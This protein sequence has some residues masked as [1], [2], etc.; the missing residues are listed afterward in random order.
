MLEDEQRER[1][2]YAVNFKEDIPQS[3]K[4][5]LIPYQ[6]KSIAKTGAYWQKLVPYVAPALVTVTA[7]LF[8]F[9]LG[10]IGM[11]T[12]LRQQ[13]AALPS[14]TIINPLTKETRSLNYGVQVLL[15]QPNFFADTRDAFI[16]SEVTFV[17][18]DLVEMQLRYFVNGVLVKSFPIL[19]KGAPGSWWDTPAGLYEIESKQVRNYSSFG[20][21]YKPWSL[22]FQSNFFIHGIPEYTNGDPVEADF[23]GGG[24]RLNTTDAEE[25]FSLVE[26]GTPVLV[27]ELPK[28]NEK[29]LYEPKVVELE[30]AHYLIADIESS[31]VLAA[32]S[33][34]T[35]A[36]I[37]SVTKLMTA[38]VAAEN[39]DLDSSVFIE[40]PT[41][42]QSLVPRLSERNKVSLLS[43]LQLT[44]LESS[45]EAS[46][47]IADQLGRDRF[48]SLMNEKAAAIGL[49]DTFFAD[50]SGL[51][52]ENISTL[53][54]LLKLT[55]YIHTNRKF[56]F[57]MTVG[58]NSPT[59]FVNNEF[60]E[61][62]NFN[63]I[64]GVENFVGGKVGETLAAGQ[65]SISLHTINVRGVTRTLAIIVLGSQDRN[66][67]VQILYRYA[68]EHF[69]R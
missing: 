56:I 5:V 6:K 23:P 59:A 49:S 38:L 65:T 25:L 37:A 31:T 27:H 13:T 29:F 7:T 17:E 35:A 19:A 18:A 14:I 60:G 69:A 43:L 54:D 26:T 9:T 48:I 36:P 33:L 22:A 62:I 53:S 30:T 11:E 50:P 32:S 47:V 45:N 2:F 21:V 55:Q 61:L 8:I 28:N 42:V 16:Q 67:D 39:L 4:G 64:A 24:I 15:E 57:E 40:Q 3:G 63:E 10:T 46:E 51:S 1:R 68:L 34:E 41:F 66:R 52:A 44:L 20:Q 58:Q 12:Y